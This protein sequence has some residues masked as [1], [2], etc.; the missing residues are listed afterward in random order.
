MSK[1]TYEASAR[2]QQLWDH[3]SDWLDE[4]SYNMPRAQDWELDA[5]YDQRF[6]DKAEERK[7][8]EREEGYGRDA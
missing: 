8:L 2:L 6:P 3:R 1:H 5:I 7:R 4:Y